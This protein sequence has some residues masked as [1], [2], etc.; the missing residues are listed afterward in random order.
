MF[1][2]HNIDTFDMGFMRAKASIYNVTN[3]KEYPTI[4]T[5]K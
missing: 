1:V 5:L 2:G 3:F 4:D